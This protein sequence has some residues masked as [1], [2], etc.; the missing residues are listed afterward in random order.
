M[1]RYSCHL[2]HFRVSPRVRRGTA[3]QTDLVHIRFY[4]TLLHLVFLLRLG[5]VLPTL[6]KQLVLFGLGFFP[7]EL[8]FKFVCFYDCSLKC[9]EAFL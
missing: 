5:F 2:T 7:F 1:C 6:L 4:Q 9:L 8:H 3:V